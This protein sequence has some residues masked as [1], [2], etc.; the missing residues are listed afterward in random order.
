[1]S[2]KRLT[3]LRSSY[4]PHGILSRIWAGSQILYLLENP[5]I[6][7]E[8]R[9]SAI[10]EGEYFCKYL[11]ESPSGKWKDVYHVT[12]V[13]DRAAIYIH[14]GNDVEDTAGC[15]LIGLSYGYANRRLRVL[16][17]REGMKKLHR[18]VQRRPFL[19][20]IKQIGKL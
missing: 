2:L 1:M 9:I 10:P 14:T 8:K 15:P 19:L 20:T 3:A 4:G 7:N 18:V 17:S 16:R 13:P 5:W 11:R 6:D 12:R